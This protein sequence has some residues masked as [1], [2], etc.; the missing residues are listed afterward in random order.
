VT[1]QFHQSY[2]YEDFVSGYRPAGDGTFTLRDGPFVKLCLRALEQ[3]ALPFVIIIDEINRG[4]LSKIFGELL[5]L[6][7]SDKR[8]PEWQVDLCYG[9]EDD[10]TTHF[11][12]PRNLYIIGT[13]NTA[14]TSLAPLDYATRRRFCSIA[15]EPAFQD[16]RFAATLEDGGLPSV[17]VEK[18]RQAMMSLNAVIAADDELRYDSCIG[19]SFF[20]PPID[21]PHTIEAQRQWLEDVVEYEIAPLIREYWSSEPKKAVNQIENLKDALLK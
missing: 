2:S 1:V 14:D 10:H 19:H 11:F 4:N 18:I 9:L 16:N 15:L 6:I 8:G 20:C 7:E 17:W 21:L 3:P 13:M 12:V 5:L